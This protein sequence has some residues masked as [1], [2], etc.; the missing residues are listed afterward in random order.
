MNIIL[1]GRK[2]GRSRVITLDSRKLLIAGVLGLLL[3]ASVGWAGYRAAM[4]QV[5]DRPIVPGMLDLEEA[6]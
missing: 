2:H 3:I 5:A 4:A 6:A 1:V